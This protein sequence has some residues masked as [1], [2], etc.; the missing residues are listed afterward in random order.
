MTFEEQV[1]EAL[2][3]RLT[4]TLRAHEY[5]DERGCCRCGFMS[6]RHADH[7]AVMVAQDLTPD[8]MATIDAA[9]IVAPSMT[10]W[11]P[12]AVAA[13]RAEPKEER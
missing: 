12:A 5:D 11:R 10:D 13:L 4:A 6:L 7:A 9:A 2:E 3:R 8:F 1:R